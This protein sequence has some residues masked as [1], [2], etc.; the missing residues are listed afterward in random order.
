[1]PWSNSTVLPVWRPRRDVI[2]AD[3]RHGWKRGRPR[4]PPAAGGRIA[5]LISTKPNA[6]GLVLSLL[7]DASGPSQPA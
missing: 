3:L 5:A 1:M 7:P 4:Q 2:S 6:G